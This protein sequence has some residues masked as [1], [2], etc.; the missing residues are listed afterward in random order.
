MEPPLCS[1]CQDDLDQQNEEMLENASAD[2]LQALLGRFRIV[3]TKGASRDDIV[4][5]LLSDV[6]RMKLHAELKGC[7]SGRR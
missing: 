3:L 1:Q 6:P 7:K 4:S 5:I 2:S